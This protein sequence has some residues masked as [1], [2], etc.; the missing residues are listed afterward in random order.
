MTRR[1]KRILI[2]ALTVLLIAGS[3][4]YYF[5]FMSTSAAIR[6]AEAFLFRRMTVAQTGAQGTYRHF[7]ITNRRQESVDGPFDDRFSADRE[8]SLKFGFF[9][10]RIEPTL[11]LGMII[12]ATAWFQN[13]EIKLDEVRELPQADL[14][15]RL[16]EAVDES[17]GRSLLIVINGFRDRFP[18]ALRKGAFVASVLDINTPVLV[19][20]WPGNQGS[21][22]RGYRRT[23][24]RRVVAAWNVGLSLQ[25]EGAGANAQ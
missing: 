1:R 7:Y 25:P 24:W 2:A 4:F 19:F 17:P 15:E 9:D 21:S 18:S 14:V 8:E 5:Y 11:G 20:D 3:W 6:H 10:T 16:R 13:E 23:T 12:N 22:L